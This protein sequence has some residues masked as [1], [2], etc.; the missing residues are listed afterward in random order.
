MSTHRQDSSGFRAG[1]GSCAR[2]IRPLALAAVALAGSAAVASAQFFDFLNNNRRWS[3]PPA[4]ADPFPQF[5]PFGQRAPETPRLE[6]GGSAAFCVRTC[7]GRYFP[8]ARNTGATP[9]QTC[10]AMCPAAATKIYHGSSIDHASVNGQRYADL[11]T[12]FVYRQK[13][14]PGCTCNGKDAFGLV[15]PSVTS[16]PTLHTGDIVATNDGLVAV[17]STSRKQTAEFTPVQSYSGLSTELRQRLAETKVVPSDTAS[18]TIP[19]KPAETTASVTASRNKRAQAEPRPVQQV[20][21][22]WWFW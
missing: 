11:D 7:D 19:V 21:R 8:I 4:Y 13:I 10:S 14:V 18:A 17:T 2:G 5:N 16:D 12:A 6:G 22:R 9:A 20:Q 1:F 3:Q 15:T